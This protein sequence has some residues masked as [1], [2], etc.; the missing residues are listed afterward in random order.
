M[1]AEVAPPPLSL[2]APWPSPDHEPASQQ[3]RPRALSNLCR[4]GT[5]RLKG[6]I[7]VRASLRGRFLADGIAEVGCSL[8]PV[9]H[10]LPLEVGHR[11]HRCAQ[12][13][14]LPALEE[15]R[16]GRCPA[17]EARRA[18]RFDR[19]ALAAS[20]NHKVDQVARLVAHFCLARREPCLV[21][22]GTQLRLMRS[23]ARRLASK[24]LV[25]LLQQ[26][27]PRQSLGEPPLPVI[28][29][30]PLVELAAVVAARLARLHRAIQLLAP[31]GKALSEESAVLREVVEDGE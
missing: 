3:R 24:G 27:I 28:P 31:L 10:P 15:R 7:T 17:D 14:E 1:G 11:C 26:G 21:Q 13:P 12:P 30:A 23:G 29:Q 8:R 18:V 19:D 5:H 25:A 20:L 4:T 2:S 9:L 16:A 6:A 22:S